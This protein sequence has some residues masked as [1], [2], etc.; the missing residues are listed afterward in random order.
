[1]SS[2]R[3]SARP[4]LTTC[5]EKQTWNEIHGEQLAYLTPERSTTLKMNSVPIEKKYVN[6][7][8][9]GRTR[10]H[11]HT[12]T[13]THTRHT[14]ARTHTHT[15]TRARAH[16]HTHT[17]ATAL[18]GALGDLGLCH[19]PEA[20]QVLSPGRQYKSPETQ[21]MTG[22]VIKKNSK[23]KHLSE[24]KRQEVIFYTHCVF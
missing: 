23:H 7:E 5:M 16:T 21:K 6:F 3:D 13:H 20:W 18:P 9:R 2:I 11:A 8:G 10:A 22:E 4:S 1:M 19:R 24:S 12:H 14:H 17:H 15:H